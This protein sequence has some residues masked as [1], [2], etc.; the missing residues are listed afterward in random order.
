MPFSSGTTSQITTGRATI[1]LW[2]SSTTQAT[3]CSATKTSY[4]RFLRLPI[5]SGDS[6]ESAR[7]FATSTILPAGITTSRTITSG[8]SLFP[9]LPQGVRDVRALRQYPH[10]NHDC[11]PVLRA[12]RFRLLPRGTLRFDPH[13]I[14]SDPLHRFPRQF[15]SPSRLFSI[16]PTNLSL[17]FPYFSFAFLSNSNFRCVIGTS[18]ITAVRFGLARS[19]Q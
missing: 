19:S 16:V 9:R 6:S 10:N 11:Q 1:R 7:S 3:S 8:I 18:R 17:T 2:C 5:A 13:G 14:L 12:P 4:G 15:S